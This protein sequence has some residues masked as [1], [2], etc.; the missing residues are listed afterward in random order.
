VRRTFDLGIT[1]SDPRA[2]GERQL[3]AILFKDVDVA[4]GSGSNCRERDLE[5]SKLTLKVS[6]IEADRR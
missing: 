5:G 4:S 3:C 1:H 6:V 2:V